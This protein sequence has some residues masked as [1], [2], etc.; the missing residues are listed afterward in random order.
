M[1]LAT[2]SGDTLDTQLLFDSSAGFSAGSLPT[3]SR[4]VAGD[5]DGDGKGDTAITLDYGNH[6]KVWAFPSGGS[7][8]DYQLLFDSSAG[9]STGSLPANSR[10]VAGDFD[11]DGKDD[12]AVTFDYAHS[13]ENDQSFR[14]MAITHSG[15]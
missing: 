3:N 7:T 9:F 1:G 11:G 8:T 6:F 2:T 5:F 13:G 4:A 12:T 15:R 10:A 14:L